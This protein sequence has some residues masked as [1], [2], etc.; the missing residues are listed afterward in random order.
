MSHQALSDAELRWNL[1]LQ[2]A[3]I[4]VFDVDLH[5]KTSVTYETWQRDMAVPG[6]AGVLRKALLRETKSQL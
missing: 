2:G 3:E 5:T 6:W 4:G 1:A